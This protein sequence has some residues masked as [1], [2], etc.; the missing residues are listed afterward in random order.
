[1]LFQY[2][3]SKEDFLN[4]QLY[5]ASKSTTVQKNIKKSRIRI[6]IIYSVCGLVIIATGNVELG[7]AFFIVAILWFFLSKPYIKKRYYRHFIK[8]IDENLSYRYDMKISIE[9]ND[10]FVETLD[11][12]GEAKIKISGLEQINEVKDYYFLKLITG[13]SL[14]L[15]KTK[16]E[17]ENTL[18]QIIEK[19]KTDHKIKHN[20][21]LDWSW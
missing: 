4:Y 7:I 14:I 20:K 17:N 3:L 15:P 5:T 11:S 9:F 13:D 8:Y 2:V 10:E 21:E 16:N 1:M 18:Q 19:L 12:V 6:P